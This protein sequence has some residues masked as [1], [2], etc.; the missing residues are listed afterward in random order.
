M[1][2]IPRRRTNS[3]CKHNLTV[4]M[5]LYNK[6][7]FVQRNGKRGDSH[8]SIQCNN[9]DK[10]VSLPKTWFLPK[11]SRHFIRIYPE[12]GSIAA[13]AALLQ[14]AY[15]EFESLSVYMEATLD[16]LV[17]AWLN[18][19]EQPGLYTTA[20]KREKLC[21]AVAL[22]LHTRPT[23]FHETIVQFRRAGNPVAEAVT[24]AY[25]KLRTT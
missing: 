5:V 25:N 13:N 2:S 20:H 10:V 21:Q 22:R 24:Y 1:G 8:V 15:R 17:E 19:D 9:C 14:S 3:L 6:N 7:H 11:S 18:W 4:V 23:V 12:D 16:E